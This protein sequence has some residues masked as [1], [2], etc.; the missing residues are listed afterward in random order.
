VR[1]SASPKLGAYTGLAGLGLVA[2]LVFG[3]PELVA[4]ALPFALVVGLGLLLEGDMDVRATVTVERE[5]VIE[6]DEVRL[7]LCLRSSSGAWRLEALVALPDELAVVHGENPDLLRLGRG[8]EQ[9]VVLTVRCQRWGGFAV[10]ETF[11]R[12]RDA[13]GLFVYE[14]RAEP[15]TALRVFPREQVLRAV[16]RP[17]ETQVFAGDEVARRR[18]AGIEFADLRPFAYGDPVRHVNW[19]VSAR[20]GSLWVNERHPERNTDVVLFLDTFAD[21]RRG[22]ASTLDLAIR[23]ASTLAARYIGRRDRVGLVSFGGVL[24]W[25]LPGSG[26]TQLYRI[27]DALLDTE[28]VLS[29]AWKDLEI[30]PRRTLPPQALVIALTPLLD[31]RSVNALL[32]L[33]ARGFDLVVL[34]TSPVPFAD[35]GDT[36]EERLAFRI[37]RLRRAALRARYRRA[38]VAVAEW[39]E[40]KPLAAALEEVTGFRRHALLGRG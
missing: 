6:G 19:R 12:G 36:A 26:V 34:E 16:L 23:A 24:R 9:T 8:Q 30:V 40:E 38:G 3:R 11:L 21:A 28:L 22:S 29:Y 15:P 32:D 20:R 37:W 2:A 13:L 1:R 27:A 39:T 4:L 10:G 18:G 31:E 33:R 5:R 25:L 14:A 35:P 7:E 17:R